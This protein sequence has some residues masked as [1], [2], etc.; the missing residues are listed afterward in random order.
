MIV[1]DSTYVSIVD[2]LDPKTGNPD[3]IAKFDQALIGGA[4][5]AFDSMRMDGRAFTGITPASFDPT[6]KTMSVR[7]AGCSALVAIS[8]SQAGKIGTL[9][10]N[11]T[12]T[13][14]VSSAKATFDTSGNQTGYEPT[15]AISADGS[16][17]C[18]TVLHTPTL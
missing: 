9:C 12:A 2:A 3:L 14:D 16:S 4:A 15:S 17:N 13:F 6:T 11:S 1:G 18:V 5:A 7:M 10:M 8:G